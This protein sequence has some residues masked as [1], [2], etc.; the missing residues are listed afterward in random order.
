M[1][2]DRLVGAYL[3]FRSRQGEDGQQVTSNTMEETN[4]NGLLTIAIVDLF[5]K[6]ISTL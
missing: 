2:M 1:Q 6:F 3:D 5:C 4:S